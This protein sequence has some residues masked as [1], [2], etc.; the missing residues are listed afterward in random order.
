M[1]IL[2]QTQSI[3]KKNSEN[4]LNTKFSQ[5]CKK[6]FLRIIS[7]TQILTKMHTCSVVTIII[8]K[9]KEKFN[10]HFFD[11]YLC[12]QDLHMFICVNKIC[13]CFITKYRHPCKMKVNM[14]FCDEF[15]YIQQNLHVSDGCYH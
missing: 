12:K 3:Q 5:R 10:A 7:K 6:P 14:H 1:H 11:D 15:L 2:T 4:N 9:K 13:T 8:I